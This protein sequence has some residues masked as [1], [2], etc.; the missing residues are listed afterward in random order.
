M[1]KGR[2]RLQGLW[3]QRLLPITST[4]VMLGLAFGVLVSNI[5]KGGAWKP[6]ASYGLIGIPCFVTR[7][8]RHRVKESMDCRWLR[9]GILQS[10]P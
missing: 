6:W 10:Q 1:T 3:E 4:S 2:Y 5:S 7:R 8:A 9:D